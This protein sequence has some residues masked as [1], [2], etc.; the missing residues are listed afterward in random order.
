M[1]LRDQ[2]SKTVTFL[3]ELHTPIFWGLLIIWQTIASS[4]FANDLGAP[5]IE[6]FSAETINADGLNW[7]AA[8]GD[9]G[10]LFFANHDGLLV[11]DGENWRKYRTGSVARSIH[12]EDGNRIWI[13]GDSELGFLDIV[14]G[15]VGTY[16]SLLEK[17][18]NP[19]L[20][21]G[22]IWQV[23]KLG[24]S[25]AFVSKDNLV[26]YT[27]G[28]IEVFPFP[29]LRRITLHN[30]QSGPLISQRGV[31]IRQA[32]GDEFPVYIGKD[33]IAQF[34]YLPDFPKL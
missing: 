12:L 32:R 27:N 16:Q 5:P 33:D 21:L 18:P 4:C 7:Q 17:L 19:E 29:A 34:V 26:T 11:F 31:G 22:E 15:K 28:V 2:S 24:D 14:D 3:K 30:S 23:D 20:Q 9:D 8:Q 25:I 6:T 10:R 13:G 1:R